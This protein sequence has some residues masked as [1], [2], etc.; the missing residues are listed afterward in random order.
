MKKTNKIISLILAA[1]MLISFAS[2]GFAA[3][4]QGEIIILYTNDVHCAIDDY[5]V[6]AAYRAELIEQGNT[7]ITV[8]AGD[9]IQGEIIGRMTEGAVAADIMNA[10]GYDY[11]VPGNHEFDYGMERFLELAETEAQYEYISCNFESLTS[12]NPVF[13][14]YAIEEINGKKVAFVGITTPE[15]VTKSTP[16][17]FKDD[18]GNFVYGFPTYD[19]KDG[20]L[21]AAVQ[22][23]V[24]A[25]KADGADVI[26]AV[27]HLG[28]EET[29]D[30]WKSTDVISGTS[31]IDV[32]LDAHSHETIEGATYKD[33]NNEDVLLSST[34]TK[35]SYFGQLTVNDDGT[36]ETELIDPDTVD[37]DALSQAAQAEYD[38][39]QA[40]VDGYNAQLDALNDPIGTSE[41]K[42][43]VYNEDKS[44][45][46]RKS[47]TNMGD[48]VT[49]AYLAC[50]D[51]ADFAIANSGGIR[52]EIAVGPVTSKDLMNINPYGNEMC[53]TSITGQQLLDALEHGAAKYPET[54]G[55][56]LQVSSNLSYDIKAWVETPVV[57][58]GN[59]SFLRVEE[60]K[61]R[62]V[63]N[64]LLNG[65]PIDPA[66]SYTVVG[67]KYVLVDGGDGYT[68]FKNYNTVNLPAVDYE[69]LIEYFTETLDGKI[70]AEQYGNPEG[71]GRIKII[72]EPCTHWCHRD[73]FLHYIWVIVNFFCS[74]FGINPV[75][76]CGEAHY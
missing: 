39:V 44:W 71:D 14:P 63:T 64:V 59:G 52:A 3:E 50:A 37:V 12:V 36:F 45:L 42:L 15:S 68:M 2:V 17:Y 43:V 40:I 38:E 8:D 35:F 72:E 54:A 25:A 60:G 24:D 70:T 46:V 30:G 56:F 49:D 55:G 53:T 31:G 22:E 58:D 74:I 57:T 51:G 48:F 27:G 20:V 62:R 7:V 4:V 34:G 75:C 23:Y 41:A 61:E 33:K 28:I 1:V 66:S 26:V 29:T 67:S 32:F 47:E 76:I 73:G 10:V 19:M 9:A 65:S 18:T 69:L 6:F 5:A 16:E 11:A 21:V 13:S